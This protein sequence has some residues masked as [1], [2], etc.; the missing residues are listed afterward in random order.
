MIRAAWRKL[1]GEDVRDR[2][3]IVDPARMQQVEAMREEQREIQHRLGI[4]TE[5]DVGA[6]LRLHQI[7]LDH[8]TRLK[9]LEAQS[10]GE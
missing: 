6:W 5:D 4:P 2:I 10:N 8:E 9:A 3:V 7:L 1:F